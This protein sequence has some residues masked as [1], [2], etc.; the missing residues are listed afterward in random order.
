MPIVN[1]QLQDKQ[2]IGDDTKIVCMNGDYIV[3]I[4][5]TN[6]DSFTELPI[7]KLVL[8]AGTEYQESD[9]VEVVDGGKTY[10]QAE[11]PTVDYIKSIEIGVYGKETEDGDPKYT[12]KPALFAC[13]KSI[14]CGAVVLKKDP[15]L[16]T[17]TIRRNGTYRAS[18]ANVDGYYEIDVLVEDKPS[19]VR[20]V[21]LYMAAGSQVIDPSSSDRTMSQVV[22]TKPMALVPG[23]IRAGYSIGGV[24]GTYD[25]ILTETEIYTDGEYLPPVGADGFSKVIVNV[26]S[27]NYA[28]LLRV[29]ESFSYNY[30]TSVNIT[31]DTSGV[32]KYENNGESIIFTAVGKGNCSVVLKDFDEAGNQ[33][34]IVHYAVIVELESDLLMPKEA[35]N[36][37]EMDLY[38]KEGVPGGIVKYTGIT[39][40]GFIRDALYIIAEGEES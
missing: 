14:L 1:L 22:I 13:E 9:I 23:N 32:L 20:T 28:K 2:A 40:D 25:K 11:L 29:S 3:R 15:V 27:S 34:G 30:N 33:V 6:C 10:W 7:K 16:E 39:G 19:E 17:L 5:C 21:E 24:V 12:S 8:K 26:G 37:D 18:D 4:K 31:L 38:L 36:L 35:S